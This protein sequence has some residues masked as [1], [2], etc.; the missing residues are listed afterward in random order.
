[1][2]RRIFF[3]IV[4]FALPAF[5]ASPVHAQS[6][7]QLDISVSPISLDLVTQP[8]TTIQDRIRVHNNTQNPIRLQVNIKKL[9]TTDKDPGFVL[10]DPTATD[11][12]VN[13]IHIDTP[14]FDIPGNE[15]YEVH[16]SITTPADAAFGYYPAIVFN[17]LSANTNV[18][19]STA[20]LSGGVAVLTALQVQS[21]NSKVEG[22]LVQFGPSRFLSQWLP[23]VFN[24]KI[25]NTGNIHMRPRGNI[26][27]SSSSGKEVGLLEINQPLSAIIPDSSRSFQATWD[28]SFITYD[29]KFVIHWDNLTH[30]RIGKYTARL[31]LVYDNGIRDATIE[32]TT[33]FWV[34]PYK[35]ILVL[36]VGIIVF[37]ISIRLLMKLY[38]RRLIKK[39]QQRSGEV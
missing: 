35:I 23:L 16:F 5:V 14:T 17:E 32:A 30:F 3:L 10:A 38:I 39:E 12:F 2:M 15:W 13:W 29:K 24:V 22:H 21:P 4:I 8:G 33:S 26:F 6:K 18:N 27:I 31:L 7:S 20:V 25:Q 11:E 37:V 34:F 28:D 36:L 19:A 1:M 9:A